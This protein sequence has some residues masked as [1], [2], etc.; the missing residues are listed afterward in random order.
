MPLKPLL[1]SVVL[2]L[3]TTIAATSVYHV[4]NSCGESKFL[5]LSNNEQGVVTLNTELSNGTSRLYEIVSDH[6]LVV[7]N[8]TDYWNANTAKLVYGTNTVNGILYYA[9]GHTNGGPLV[10]RGFR[11]ISSSPSCP[12]I[13]SPDGST[14]GCADD[15]VTFILTLCP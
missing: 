14:K 7:A 9:I 1:A 10:G 11:L 2:A 4:A 3:S 13:S 8:T 12:P 6:S 5:T 15:N